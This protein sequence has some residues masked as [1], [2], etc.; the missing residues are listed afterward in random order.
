[1]TKKVNFLVNLPTG[2]IDEVDEQFFSMTTTE[3]SPAKQMRELINNM[4]SEETLSQLD[5]PQLDDPLIDLLN[6]LL[7]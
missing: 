2:K 6:E 5:I 3:V 7:I 4:E 1:M